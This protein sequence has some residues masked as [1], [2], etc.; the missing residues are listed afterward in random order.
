[1]KVIEAAKQVPIKAIPA[2][3][4]KIE[5]TGSVWNSNSYHWEEKN[6]T[7]WAAD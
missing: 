2:A 4:A 5:G 1:M 3:A 7:K 6:V